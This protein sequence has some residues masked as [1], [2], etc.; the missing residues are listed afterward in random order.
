[1]EH[2]ELIQLLKYQEKKV[3]GQLDA[4]RQTIAIMERALTG[5][6]TMPTPAPTSTSSALNRL[7]KDSERSLE[8]SNRPGKKR[9]KQGPVVKN[10]NELLPAKGK[11]ARRVIIPNEYK[12][13]ASYTKKIAY[14]LLHEGPMSSVQLVDRIAEL[15]PETPR[16]KI[17]RS[18]TIG[19]SNMYR[20]G[21]VKAKR[22]GRR[23]I[24]GL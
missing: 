15:E 3:E 24:Y 5:S 11:K 14:L 17:E 12:N 2:H 18:V 1:M 20:K 9:E 7:L 8:D 19:A 23:Y 21:L 6:S 13:S 4:I 16:D 10:G 22:E